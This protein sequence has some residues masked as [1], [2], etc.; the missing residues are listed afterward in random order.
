LTP[1]EEANVDEDVVNDLIDSDPVALDYA[2]DNGFDA[3]IWPHGNMNNS[4]Y[5]AVVFA[6]EQIKSAIGNSGDFSPD[7]PS[8]TKSLL[9][10]KSSTPETRAELVKE[11]KRLV[12]VLR[13]PSHKD[14]LEEA[15]RQEEELEE[16]EMAKAITR[17]RADSALNYRLQM[18]DAQL[19]P[20]ASASNFDP[21]ARARYEALVNERY[22]IMIMLGDASL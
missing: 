20:L 6:P 4:A 19:G 14:D 18:I 7:N 10:F 3:V 11:H 17:N 12:A 9:L 21:A 2:S 5:T 22:T 13:S 8:I 1:F 15:D 16:Y